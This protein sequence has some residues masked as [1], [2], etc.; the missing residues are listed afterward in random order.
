MTARPASSWTPT[1]VGDVE[2]DTPAAPIARPSVLPE[3]PIIPAELPATQAEVQPIQ[4][5]RPTTLTVKPIGSTEKRESSR[6]TSGGSANPLRQGT[7]STILSRDLDN[8]LR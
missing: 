6:A 3:Q 5:E 7:T 2:D 8:P 4:V 1:E